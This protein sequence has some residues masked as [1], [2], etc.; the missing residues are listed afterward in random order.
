MKMPPKRKA[1]LPVNNFAKNSVQNRSRNPRE[2]NHNLSPQKPIN[3]RKTEFKTAIL[4]PATVRGFLL[5][6][7]P[8]KRIKPEI[9]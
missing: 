7:I 9:M 8:L 5:F 1:A 2:S 4:K 3:Q 6:L